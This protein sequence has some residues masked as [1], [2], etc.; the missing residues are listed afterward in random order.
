VKGDEAMYR[1]NYYLVED[2]FIEFNVYNTNKSKSAIKSRRIALAAILMGLAII[3]IRLAGLFGLKG[4]IP[5][6]L[7]TL[8][9]TSKYSH[10][11]DSLVRYRIRKYL[12]EGN[13]ESMFGSRQVSVND[14][15]ILVRSQTSN[16]HYNWSAVTKVECTDDYIYV[17]MGQLK[18]AIFPITIF[19]SDVERDGFVDYLR[20]KSNLNGQRISV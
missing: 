16:A 12:R 14:D 11:L 19:E 18:V 17:L 4:V 20:M 9:I 15:G 6:L 7:L 3:S 10:W 13:S 2:D 1:Y 8:L 5:I